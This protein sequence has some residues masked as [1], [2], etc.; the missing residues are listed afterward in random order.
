[1]PPPV[2]HEPGL[3]NRG[4]ASPPGFVFQSVQP[5]DCLK[6]ALLSVPFILWHPLSQI[7]ETLK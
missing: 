1:M 7:K 5:E 4:V 6:E 2:E 3:L